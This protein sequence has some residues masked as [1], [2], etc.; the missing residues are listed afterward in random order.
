MIW[1]SKIQFVYLG[2]IKNKGYEDRRTTIG[3]GA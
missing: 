1:L 2:I 3:N